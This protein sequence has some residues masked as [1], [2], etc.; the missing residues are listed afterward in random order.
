MKYKFN[1]HTA[2]MLVEQPE[3]SH[4][5]IGEYIHYSPG[6][7]YGVSE[8]SQLLEF[9]SEVKRIGFTIHYCD[10]D[11]NALIS[12]VAFLCKVTLVSGY[13]N[14][15]F[16]DSYEKWEDNI[17]ESMAFIEKRIRPGRKEISFK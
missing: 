14:V 12:S 5:N 1:Q 17:R 7:L 11:P 2:G 9:M 13:I 15:M 4:C 3:R 6:L 16:F 10:N 8:I